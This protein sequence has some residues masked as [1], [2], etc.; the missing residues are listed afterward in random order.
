MSLIICLTFFLSFLEYFSSLYFFFLMIR[1]PPR[2]TLFPYTTLFR[3]EA[4][5]R[6]RP[7]RPDPPG[8]SA[9]RLRQ[10]RA[11]LLRR[12]A[13]P[14]RGADRA[15]RAHSPPGAPAPRR[16]PAPLPAQPDPARASPP[17]ARNRWDQG[18][19]DHSTILDR[20]P[21]LTFDIYVSV[22]PAETLGNSPDEDNT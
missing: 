9:L 14:D 20:R 1:R 12:A 4:L 11:H 7:L 21:M 22:G 19:N 3:S 8:Q 16:G 5:P 18:L 13:R 6:P 17:A 15:D 10:R 2:S